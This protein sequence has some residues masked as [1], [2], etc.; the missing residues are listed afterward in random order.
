M[1]DED[2]LQEAHEAAGEEEFGQSPKTP[3]S[4]SRSSQDFMSLEGAARDRRVVASASSQK[5]LADLR[6]QL[7]L[8]ERQKED[9]REKIKEL[10]KLKEDADK[11]IVQKPKLTER[12]QDLEKEAR[13]HAKMERE[14][15]DQKESLE[16]QIQDLSDQLEMSTLDKEMAEEKAE[17]A[18]EELAVEKDRI[19]ELLVDLEVLREQQ[20]AED[21]Q[22]NALTTDEDGQPAEVPSATVIQLTRQNERLKEALIR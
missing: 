20:A 1:G 18:L 2:I 13:D 16:R 9:D 12:V 7:T 11:F 4:A 21:E 22:V 15:L 5:D 14:W 3:I 10:Q 17:A 19:E 6:K 8:L